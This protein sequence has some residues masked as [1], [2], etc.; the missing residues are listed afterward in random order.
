[1]RPGDVVQLFRRP[2]LSQSATKTLLRKVWCCDLQHV[3]KS[4][5]ACTGVHVWAKAA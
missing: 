3:N 5:P 4:G 2:G 1:M